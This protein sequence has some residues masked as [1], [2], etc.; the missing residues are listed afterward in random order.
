MVKDK[1]K[2]R[3][4]WMRRIVMT[5]LVTGFMTGYFVIVVAQITGAYRCTSVYVQFGDAYF[6]ELAYYS[7]KFTGDDV[8]KRVQN[9]RQYFIDSTGKVELKYSTSEKAWTFVF[10]N[11]PERGYLI[12]S[13]ETVSFDIADMA[14]QAW[15]A[16]TE[17]GVKPMD[18]LAMKC[19]DCTEGE[20]T[21]E[22]TCKDNYRIC[23]ESHI[24]FE[25]ESV[26]ADCRYY[27]L[28]LRTKGGL[29]N[30]PNANF[31]VN[32]EFQVLGNITVF[33]REIYVP[34]QYNGADDEEKMKAFILFTGRR[35][36]IMGPRETEDPDTTVADFKDFLY[37]KQNF[38]TFRNNLMMDEII[39]MFRDDKPN[40]DLKSRH[41]IVNNSFRSYQ[42][43][44]FSTPVD[45]GTPSYSFDPADV[46]WAVAEPIDEE[47]RG[48]NSLFEMRPNDDD[49]IT[50]RY[51]CSDCRDKPDLCRNDG[52]V[53]F[54]TLVSFSKSST[55]RIELT[56]NCPDVVCRGWIL[57]LLALLRV[58][59]RHILTCPILF[60]LFSCPC[61]SF[62]IFTSQ[63]LSMR[64]CPFLYGHR[65]FWRRNLR[66][67][68]KAMYRK[69]KQAQGQPLDSPFPEVTPDPLAHPPLSLL[70]HFLELHPRYIWKPLSVSFA[71]LNTREPVLLCDAKSVSQ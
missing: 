12:K 68:H 21:D 43:L 39:R 67:S 66:P 54:N 28:D 18:F 23:N 60:L 49:V 32:F 69:W 40:A 70:S 10:T 11:E 58:S 3:T 19:T 63:W 13:E 22:Y 41:Y 42:P 16:N 50:A 52:E 26:P 2:P 1:T 9:N 6:P 8:S 56:L 7:G 15:Y 62:L 44:Y 5:L 20:V 71:G 14:S 51:L 36:A 34:F 61:F 35:W 17:E 37:S 48:P 53:S 55:G 4:K 33:D 30:F 29:L 31:F 59:L 27:G 45:Y 24:G 65:L 46:Q 25:C 47:L 38:T 57:Q 64:I